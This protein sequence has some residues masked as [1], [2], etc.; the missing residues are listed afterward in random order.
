MLEEEALNGEPL[1]CRSQKKDSLRR[2]SINLETSHF[3]R[4]PGARRRRNKG[5]RD[6]SEQTPSLGFR[7]D[8]DLTPTAGGGKRQ[9]HRVSRPV[10]ASSALQRGE[11]RTSASV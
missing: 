7:S 1:F 6:T 3:T 8:P 9:V 4:L 5:G 2:G 11:A 10:A